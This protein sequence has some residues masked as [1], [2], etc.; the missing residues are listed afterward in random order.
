[1]MIPDPHTTTTTTITP[2]P[3]NSRGGRFRYLIDSRES[4]F[5]ESLPLHTDPALPRLF[6]ASSPKF[7]DVSVAAA[8]LNRV[9]EE[10]LIGAYVLYPAVYFVFSTYVS[11]GIMVSC[12]W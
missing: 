7:A 8:E 6:L 4:Y 9:L 12:H 10:E 11:Y 5:P 2:L 1:M 3:S